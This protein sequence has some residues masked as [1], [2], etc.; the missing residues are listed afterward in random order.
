MKHIYCCH[1]AQHR[2][3]SATRVFWAGGVLQRGG[4]RGSW[5]EEEE[6]GPDH[7]HE[8]EPPCPRCLPSVPHWASQDSSC[9]CGF[10]VVESRTNKMALVWLR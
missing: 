10:M 2:Q 5:R 3:E 4:G 9:V 7:S 1:G 8:T 6:H